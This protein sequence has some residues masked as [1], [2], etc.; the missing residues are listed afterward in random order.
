MLHFL[1]HFFFLHGTIR[2]VK[3]FARRSVAN[4]ELQK[5]QDAFED[6]KKSLELDPSLRSKDWQLE[7]EPPRFFQDTLGGFRVD[8][9]Y[10]KVI[11]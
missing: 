8:V 4:E 1:G 3:A 6:L 9:W 2:Y 7:P 10:E 5:W 11:N